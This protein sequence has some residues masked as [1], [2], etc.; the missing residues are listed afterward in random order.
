MSAKTR[1]KQNNLE[2]NWEWNIPLL[3][4]SA[5]VIAG[6]C[7]VSTV[8]Y[9]WQSSSMASELLSQAKNSQE[10][11]QSKDQ[12]K[13]LSR[14]VRLVPSDVES[15]AELAK[16]VD[17]QESGPNQNVEFARS[18]LAAAIGACGLDPQYEELRKELRRKLIPRLLQF[19]AAR[20]VEAEEQ[21]NLLQLD[22][23]D[24]Q[25]IGWLA[26]SLMMQRSVSDFQSRDTKKFVKEKDYFKWLA[27]QPVGQVLQVAV[28][29]NPENIDLA[30]NLL[31]VF[32]QRPDWFGNDVDATS[33]ARTAELA[34]QTLDRL[35]A[36]RDDGQ[37]Q[38]VAYTNLLNKDQQRARAIL[39]DAQRLALDRLTE[40]SSRKDADAEKISKDE[41]VPVW[42]WQIALE[43]A[44]VAG[45]EESEQVINRLIGLASERIGIKQ[46]EE[47]YVRF[48]KLKLDKGELELAIAACKSGLDS[49]KSS[50]GLRRLLAFTYLRLDRP[51]DAAK[52]ITEIQSN[53]D[54]RRKQLDGAEG[55]GMSTAEK[56]E[57]RQQISE[58]QWM[59]T[60]LRGQ[61][62]I[63]EDNFAKAAKLLKDAYKTTLPIASENRAE[64]GLLLASCYTQTREWDL[65]GQIYDE[66]AVLR[67]SD[68]SISVNAVRAWRQAGSP[69]RA[70]EQVLNLDDSTYPAALE[71]A[72]LFASKP[73]TQIDRRALLSAIKIARERL[74]AIPVEEQ[75][76][77]W[78][79]EL[80]EL[81]FSSEDISES[82]EQQL[83]SLNK[84]EAIAEKYSDVSEVQVQAAQDL[85]TFGR[86]D[87]SKVAISRLD[88]IAKISGTAEDKANLELTKVSVQVI[89]KDTDGALKLIENAMKSI[90]EQELNLAKVGAQIAIRSNRMDQAYSVIASVPESKMDFEAI[91]MIAGIADSIGDTGASQINDAMSKLE[92]LG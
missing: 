25:A 47:A 59:A 40:F 82:K 11:G 20:A 14:Y 80:L 76:D 74:D 50:S 45:G 68:R 66:C 22:E 12:V 33:Q 18:R 5:I 56:A 37:A 36:K 84:L 87:A 16:A 53:A 57:V 75:I 78:R 30:Q 70:S 61:L 51:E 72:L 24:A 64:A 6:I 7:C 55:I 38:L 31:F 71:R 90:P 27:S 43:Y 67:P 62:A 88:Q 58:E 4:K 29:A 69:E 46:R 8:L 79:L 23:G 48:A 17:A 44:A 89:K 26:Q 91:V 42:D 63:L 34:K 9:F 60:L 92:A 39:E 13:W 49:V 19:G 32:N 65:A 52:A 86:D 85:A 41:Y 81:R 2:S 83:N 28:E 1:A 15:L 35:C 3:Y 54:L 21:I 77:P 10:R 73:A